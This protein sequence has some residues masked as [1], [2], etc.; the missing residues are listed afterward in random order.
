MPPLHV[1]YSARCANCRYSRRY[2]AAQLT[3]DTKASAHALS[4]QHKVTITATDLRTLTNSV[5]R[6]VD[7]TADAVLP[8]GKAPF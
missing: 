4:W 2:G 6:V 7:H 1:H 3:A 5:Y 8:N